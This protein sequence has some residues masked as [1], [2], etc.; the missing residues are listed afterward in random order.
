MQK[1]GNQRRKKWLHF[2][3]ERKLFVDN[4]GKLENRENEEDEEEKCEAF[5][6]SK[7]IYID[8]GY[9]VPLKDVVAANLAFK[10]EKRE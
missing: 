8:M 3:G 9:Y 2:A 5:D 7:P 6:W 4:V 1:S 10:R